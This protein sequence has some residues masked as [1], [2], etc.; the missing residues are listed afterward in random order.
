[1]DEK[2]RNRKGKQIFS[3]RR[4]RVDFCVHKDRVYL[5]RYKGQTLYTCRLWLS[6]LVLSDVKLFLNLDNSKHYKFLLSNFFQMISGQLRGGL[7]YYF[8]Y[9]ASTTN[10]DSELL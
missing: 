8:V 6:R 2:R 5:Y 3:A 7:L 10:P 4:R 9:F 1:M